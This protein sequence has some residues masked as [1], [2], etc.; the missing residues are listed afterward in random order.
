M[1][2]KKEINMGEHLQPGAYYGDPG[3]EAIVK[4]SIVV[5]KRY[6]NRKLYDTNE[7]KY[8]TLGDIRSL[9]KDGHEIMVVDNN[10]KENIT[11]LTLLQAFYEVQ[12]KKLENGEADAPRMTDLM[13]A[14]RA[15]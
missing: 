10:T 13:T 6:K 12:K 4:P 8:V 9:I 1:S 7:S 5:V 11:T 14:L 15:M 3:Y 2:I